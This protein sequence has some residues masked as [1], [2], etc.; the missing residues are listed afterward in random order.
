MSH[1]SDINSISI[2]YKNKYAFPCHIL[3]LGCAKNQYPIGISRGCQREFSCDKLASSNK[4]DNRYI[5]AMS[6]G[7]NVL[8]KKYWKNQVVKRHCKRACKNCEG[9]FQFSIYF[10]CFYSLFI[11]IFILKMYNCFPTYSKFS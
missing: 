10:L 6:L 3:T 5:Q 4:C 11:R 2:F 1:S 8:L 7:C 9:M